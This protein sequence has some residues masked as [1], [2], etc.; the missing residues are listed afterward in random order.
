MEL[1]E[2]FTDELQRFIENEFQ[3]R[4]LA[5]GCRVHDMNIADSVLL[6]LFI[7]SNG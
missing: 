6:R 1:I 2:S 3:G 4:W 5:Q 7:S